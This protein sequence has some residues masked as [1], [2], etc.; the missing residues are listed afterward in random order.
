MELNCKFNDVPSG[1]ANA[2]QPGNCKFNDVRERH[3]KCRPAG[4]SQNYNMVL[5]CKFNAVPSAIANA[6]QQGGWIPG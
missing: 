6:A 1:I 5:N 4:T 3:C 2:A